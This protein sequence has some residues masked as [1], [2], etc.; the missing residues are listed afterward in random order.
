MK[1]RTCWRRCYWCFLSPPVLWLWLFAR[2]ILSTMW[3]DKFPQTEQFGS[4]SLMRRVTTTTLG[5]WKWWWLSFKWAPSNL[6]ANPIYVFVI[7][8]APLSFLGPNCS[9]L[10]WCF[11]GRSSGGRLLSVSADS[12]PLNVQPKYLAPTQIII[13]IIEQAFRKG[14]NP[15][16]S[17][18]SQSQE[19]L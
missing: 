12:L 18:S 7:I 11:N 16:S 9:L 13:L 19:W 14:D 2:R 3:A 6:L 4:Y 15:L 17:T 1:T 8:T 10:S 5:S